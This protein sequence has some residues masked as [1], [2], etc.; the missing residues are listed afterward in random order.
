MP[1]E[2]IQ[3]E[4]TQPI[5]ETLDFNNPAYTFHAHEN[6]EWRQQGPYLVCKS[7]EIQHA[8]FVGMEK[9][10]AG[11]DKEGKPILQRRSKDT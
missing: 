7:C 11:I 2:E 3:D 8:V 5:E 6:H 10:M 1:N 4:E 9:I